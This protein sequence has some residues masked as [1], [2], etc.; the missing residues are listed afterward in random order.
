MA[1]MNSSIAQY[2]QDLWISRVAIWH[3]RS[4]V[5]HLQ[6]MLGDCGEGKR[7]GR[8]L[9]QHP[10]VR[11]VIEIESAATDDAK[12]ERTLRER[13]M[14]SFSP[15]PPL[16]FK[17]CRPSSP[18]LPSSKVRQRL[19][20]PYL[21]FHIRHLTYSHTNFCTCFSFFVGINPLE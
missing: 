16:E 17:Q 15:P 9:F 13:I 8:V 4:V 3:V 2:S 20:W 19:S 10:S 18:L 6:R 1:L 21:S 5:G 7:C 12:D 14:D 11:D